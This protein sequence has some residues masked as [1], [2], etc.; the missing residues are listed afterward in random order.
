MSFSCWKIDFKNINDTSHLVLKNKKTKEMM[1]FPQ[2]LYSTSSPEVI[3][4]VFK[5]KDGINIECKKIN[6]KEIP[7][8]KDFVQTIAFDQCD[9]DGV[10]KINTGKDPMWFI[11]L[12]N[13]NQVFFKEIDKE[14]GIYLSNLRFRTLCEDAGFADITPF[15]T[16]GEY[17]I[18]GRVVRGMMV[19]KVNGRNLNKVNYYGSEQT[20]Q[21]IHSDTS[22][23]IMA[24]LMDGLC[25]SRDRHYNNV[26]ISDK[27][28]HSIDNTHSFGPCLKGSRSVYLGTR[29]LKEAN[30]ILHYKNHVV[31][32]VIGKNFPEMF[33]KLIGKLS[34]MHLDDIAE[35]Y[36][37]VKA[38]DAQ[39]LRESARSILLSGFEKGCLL[40][41]K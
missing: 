23:I 13:L 22:R 26:M 9:I 35:D 38:S 37:F 20:F 6:P 16:Y 8:Q 15:V 24:A 12:S 10:E 30:S 1:A 7:V 28:V 32:G 3:D 17:E 36:Y 14:S 25:V 11:T 19:E 39:H 34:E 5:F 31:G 41:S 27:G 18:D 4:A 40:D 29:P 21:I 33:E 2:G